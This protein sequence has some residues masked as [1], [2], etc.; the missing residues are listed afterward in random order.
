MVIRQHS[1]FGFELNA[2]RIMFT[3]LGNSAAAASVS[4]PG[5]RL[6]R[7]VSLTRHL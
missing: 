3:D 1:L 2:E 5:P 7:Q 6:E 4:T